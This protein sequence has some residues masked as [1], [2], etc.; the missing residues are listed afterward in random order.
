M[1]P[2]ASLASCSVPPDPDR[3]GPTPF[4]RAAR[5][6]R[7]RLL[8]SAHDV[9]GAAP[10]PPATGRPT[11]PPDAAAHAT[12]PPPGPEARSAARSPGPGPAPAA[13]AA[14]D[15]PLPP[16]PGAASA[17]TPLPPAPGVVATELEPDLA[18]PPEIDGYL[19]GPPRITGREPAP[20][21]EAAEPLLP[22]EPETGEIEIR[23]LV[24][25]LGVHPVSVPPPDRAAPG[26][27]HPG[28]PE[29]GSPDALEDRGAA[30]DAR[31]ALPRQDPP[32][33]PVDPRAQ[34]AGV[35]PAG[36]VGPGAPTSAHARPWP[37]V[38]PPGSRGPTMLAAAMLFL[39]G[40]G[41][42]TAVTLLVTEDDSPSA[43]AV[44]PESWSRPSRA[45]AAAPAATP[46][47]GPVALLPR[48]FAIDPYGG[49]GEHQEQA[50]LAVDGRLSTAWATQRYASGALGKPGVGLAVT[51]VRPAR[52]RAIT[53]RT[54]TPGFTTEIY[55]ARGGRPASGAPQRG[56]IRLAGRST[57]R[58][59]RPIRLAAA[60]PSMRH[61]LVWVVA[62]AP[63]RDRAEISEVGL[64]G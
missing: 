56:W 18:E 4:Q 11:P 42:G 25:E 37:L 50:R 7:D 22:P 59:G 49:D 6:A 40:L 5:R 44:A 24:A 8:R 21:I 3:R 16:V 31:R 10:A 63:G 53:I 34:P 55:G 23:P 33:N 26:D 64:R 60:A 46:P 35:A 39:G 52:A 47:A 58:S 41:A 48:A 15:T 29:A 45:A 36:P 62:L 54:P 20:P 12:G 1:C 30:L 51:A 2:P 14:A 57:V 28:A 61:W 9:R 43:S 32:A 27:A 19:P 38:P 13:H 17:E